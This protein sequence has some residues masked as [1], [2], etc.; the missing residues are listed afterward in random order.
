MRGE[1][2][3]LV[4]AH[5]LF[6]NRSFRP[7]LSLSLSLF[8]FSFSFIIS[9]LEARAPTRALDRTSILRSREGGG[10]KRGQEG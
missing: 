6:I 10:R 2:N 9:R 8:S 3:V 7:S 5:D 4:A 1:I